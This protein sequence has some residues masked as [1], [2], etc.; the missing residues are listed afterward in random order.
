MKRCD[1]Q[2]SQACKSKGRRGFLLIIFGIFFIILN[3]NFISADCTNSTYSGTGNWIIN[4]TNSPNVCS[5]MSITLNGNLSIQEGGNLTLNNVVLRMNSSADGAQNI[6][7]DNNATFI[8]NKSSVNYLTTYAW[9]YIYGKPNSTIKYI[10]SFFGNYISQSIYAN[11][12]LFIQN[13]TFGK[14]SGYSPTYSTPQ[15]LNIYAATT[16]YKSVL[17]N[18]S[19][20]FQKICFYSDVPGGDV[21]LTLLNTDYMSSVVFN[22]NTQDC[23]V[24][25]NNTLDLKVLNDNLS[26]AP[27]T[28]V[29]ITDEKGNSVYNGTTNLEGEI[30]SI[31]LMHRILNY[32]GSFFKNYTLSSNGKTFG[33]VMGMPRK[34]STGNQISIGTYEQDYE[35]KF[36]RVPYL[37][38]FGFTFSKD[39]DTY[40]YQIG[41]A[42]CLS[43]YNAGFLTS[44]STWAWYVAGWGR[45][46]FVDSQLQKIWL[47][48]LQSKGFE[49]AL[50]S[51][52]GGGDVRQSTIYAFNNWSECFGFPMYYIEHG[53]DT[54]FLVLGS[55]AGANSTSNYY[56]LD[57]VNTTNV[58][59]FWM[60]GPLSFGYN[61]KYRT[62][63]ENSP[64][65]YNGWKAYDESIDSVTGE[66]WSYGETSLFPNFTNPKATLP[67]EN[68]NGDPINLTSMIGKIHL[69]DNAQLS[70][71]GFFPLHTPF[72]IFDLQESKDLDIIYDHLTAFA[73]YS[74]TLTEVA[75]YDGYFVPVAVLLNYSSKLERVAIIG[76]DKNFTVTN[77]GEYEI[78]GV[79]VY[80]DTNGA[81]INISYANTT[82]GNYLLSIG[83]DKDEMML[84]SLSPGE[85]LTVTYDIMG[86][87]DSDIPKITEITNSNVELKSAVYNSTAKKTEFKVGLDRI[88]TYNST[89]STPRL[90]NIT[91]EN[92]NSS[93]T[94]TILRDDLVWTNYSW[95]GN[96]LYIW[97]FLS[98]HNF[99]IQE[100]QSDGVSCSYATS[101]LGGYCVHNICRST[102][103]YCG[104]N[105]C[106]TGET[107]SSCSGD[108][109]TCTEETTTSGSS[110]TYNPS[111]EQ[112]EEGYSKLLRKTQKVQF[113]INNKIYTAVINFVDSENKKVEVEIEGEGILVELSEGS[114]GKIDL[115][116]DGYYDLQISVKEIMINDYVDLEFKEIYEGI[117]DEEKEEQE[118]PSKIEEKIKSWMW[119]F[120]GIILLI[121][122]GIVIRRLL[123]N[124]ND[125]KKLLKIEYKK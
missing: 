116:N 1:N 67:T 41:N 49:L 80:P 30:N 106:D 110:A 55:G 36:S 11:D 107:C 79:V 66:R 82:A 72:H 94:Y 16:Q 34:N 93:K 85:S 58:S 101:C 120:G 105:Y 112:L 73:A 13:T 88:T 48:D 76:G 65:W 121:V 117:P 104:D 60:G 63:P 64:A 98:E 21:H 29:N 2:I 14:L 52:T 28:A 44:V 108:C 45:L 100:K 24:T 32:S 22:S 74:I 31:S 40:D 119:I 17:I 122:I 57:L 123:K 91:I 124:R 84:P 61:G 109:G 92:L 83:L 18:N 3:V 15:C 103:T 118:E 6:T 53:G 42:S 25:I 54:E 33:L 102:L 90:T 113:T 62:T 77:N 71:T 23:S 51:A 111:S 56:L 68:N 27:S 38:D 50:H 70:T 114:V 26:A 19:N 8:F 37:Y 75:R 69:R 39:T 96:T 125:Y 95:S 20:L 89:N 7:V 97:T 99:T 59:Y 78:E 12:Y 86:A 35:E 47:L 9:S 5:D 43:F 46:G 87:Y 10:D 115:N 81:I 4:S